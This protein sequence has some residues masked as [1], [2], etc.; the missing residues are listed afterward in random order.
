[1]KSRYNLINKCKSSAVIYIIFMYLVCSGELLCCWSL[2]HLQLLFHFS[3]R[4]YCL[5]E[6]RKLKCNFWFWLLCFSYYKE[7]LSQVAV[8][9][10]HDLY[11]FVYLSAD[12]KN[13]C[14]E[15][16]NKQNLWNHGQVTKATSC[17][18]HPQ[19]T[20]VTLAAIH[21]YQN[22]LSMLLVALL[23]LIQL[24]YLNIQFQKDI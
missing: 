16:A 5:P 9:M 2:F 17:L 12:W 20:A 3:L 11:I 4:S 10:K 13:W 22:L 7:E 6:V 8:N 14:S 19:V 1:M 23:L 21:C 15:T 24:I 18:K